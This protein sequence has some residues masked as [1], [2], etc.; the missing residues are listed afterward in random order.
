MARKRSL[1]DAAAVQ[2][3]EKNKAV[4]EE[5]APVVEEVKTSGAGKNKATVAR[6]RSLKDAAADQLVEKN[7]A[8]S[9]E[10]APVIEEVQTP[11]AERTEAAAPPESTDQRFFAAETSKTPEG[12]KKGHPSLKW[13]AILLLIGFAGGFF[14]GV[15]QAIGPANLAFLLIGFIGGCLF[16]RFIKII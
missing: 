6:K 11:D 14:F 5:E 10:Q 15:G 9:E 13:I 8:V 1:K 7:K 2:L 4:S 16:G 3:V 12:G